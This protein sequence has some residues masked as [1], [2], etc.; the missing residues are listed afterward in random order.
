MARLGGN[1]YCV[2]NETNLFHV[3][4]PNRE[5]GIGIDALPAGIRNSKILTGNNLAQ[6]ANIQELPFIDAAFEDEELKN[7][8]QYYAVNPDDMEK[9]LHR[10]AKQLLD[11][12][13]VYEAWQVLLACE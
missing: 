4:K 3:P 7:I 12:N 10:Y 13:K 2:V 8:I 5:L 11:E 9:E 6:L 1:R